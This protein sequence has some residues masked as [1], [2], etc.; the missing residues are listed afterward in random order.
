MTL[1][2]IH[3]NL[4]EKPLTLEACVVWSRLKFEEHFSNSISQLLFNFPLEM[5]TSSGAP[6]WRAS[7]ANTPPG[8]ARA[9]LLRF[10]TARLA[11]S[12]RF[13]SPRERDR[14]PHPQPQP[15][16]LQRAA[17]KV[18]DPTSFGHPRSGPKRPPQIAAFSVDDPLHMDFIVAAANLRAQNYGLKGS[19]DIEFM[20]RAAESVMVPEFVPKQ[21][22]DIPSP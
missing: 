8:S 10:L 22:A 21:A 4:V 18:A 14:P 20:K 2:E 9:R 15:R 5:S 6:F 13:G 7:M 16:V 11:G 19:T 17:S 1:K 12:G 3:S